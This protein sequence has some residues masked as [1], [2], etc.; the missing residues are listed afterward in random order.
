MSQPSSELTFGRLDKVVPDRPTAIRDFIAHLPKRNRVTLQHVMQH[1]GF[2]WCHQR[3]LRVR[4]LRFSGSNEAVNPQTVDRLDDPR[5]LL[6]VF[7]Q[8][9]LRPPWSHC[10]VYAELLAQAGGS[11]SDSGIES[12]HT[13]IVVSAD[14]PPT[15]RS[16]ERNR[17]DLDERDWYWGDISQSEVAEVM[18]GQPDGAFLVRDASAGSASAFTLTER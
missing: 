4:L 2:I 18:R 3:L 9:L 6:V 10:F 12:P 7:V 17:R 1:L 14:M 5:L 13:T 8:I 11:T 15:P 16:V